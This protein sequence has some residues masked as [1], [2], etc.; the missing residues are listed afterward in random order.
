MRPGRLA[1]RLKR[2]LAA[3]GAAMAAWACAAAPLQAQAARHATQVDPA[4]AAP[5]F[6]QRAPVPRHAARAIALAPHITELIHAAGA[7]ERIVATVLS[8]DYPPEAL[9]IPRIGDGIHVNVEQALALRPDLIVA[10]L[11][12]GA[13]QVMAP[14]ASRLGIPLIYSRP[15]KLADIPSEIVRFGRLFG[16]EAHANE[17]ARALTRRLEALGEHYARRKPVSVFIEV[18]A[19][20]LYTI[21]NDPLL[22]DALRLC[23]GVNLYADAAMAAPQVILEDLLARRPDV[24][25]VAPAGAD[26]R[27]ALLRWT[28]LKLP[29][30]LR[31]HVHALDPDALFRPGPRLIDA[32]EQLCRHL[33]DAR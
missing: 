4:G 21:G 16:T 24:V 29:A 22:N 32:A 3:C 6:A 5:A 20:P 26:E 1:D 25:I 31:G 17:T 8:S 7:G 28:G 23:G 27:D 15:G 33:D 18:G 19:S 11:P 30:A 13:A 12:H 14:A 9:A 2:R 10:W